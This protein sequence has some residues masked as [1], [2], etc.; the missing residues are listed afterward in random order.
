VLQTTGE[1]TLD[2][3]FAVSRLQGMVRLPAAK[4]QS[5]LAA[6]SSSLALYLDGAILEGETAIPVLDFNSI[7]QSL[8]T[9]I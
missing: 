2:V 7:L 4:I 5:S 3:G 9:V 6:F 8:T 1:Q